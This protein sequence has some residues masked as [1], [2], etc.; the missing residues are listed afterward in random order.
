[1]KFGLW[2]LLLPTLALANSDQCVIQQRTVSQG[3][4]E[5]QERSEVRREITPLPSGQW[6]CQVSFRARIGAV[7]HTA[8]G[9]Y[10]WPGD[11][12]QQ[13]AC[14][15]AVKT[16]TDLLRQRVGKT[17]VITDQVVVCRDQP[18]LI[19]LKDIKPGT[20]AM[21]HQFRPHPDYP[22]AF[23]HQGTQCRWFLDSQYRNSDIYTFQGIICQ[24][25]NGGW[26]V[27]DKF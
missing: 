3:E 18:D 7:W 23:W 27:L 19:T 6:R 1:M 14:G 26:A 5:I 25:Q 11:R 10:D 15:V 20:V 2:L 16:A 12:S 9:E 17:K 21:L 22:N 13:E 8:F 4:V 24:V